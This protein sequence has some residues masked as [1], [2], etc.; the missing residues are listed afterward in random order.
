[1]SYS[2]DSNKL[3]FFMVALLTLFAVSACSSN[4]DLG[5][6]DGMT[7]SDP[8]YNGADVAATNDAGDGYGTASAV[9]GVD[10][11]AISGSANQAGLAANA[12]DIIYFDTDSS[13]VNADARY[14]LDAQARWLNNFPKT[15]ITVE[16]HAD[17]RGTREYN[18]AL[19]DRR[20]SAVK[21]YL[22]AIGIDP[23]R[24]N[25]ISYG[26]EQPVIVGTGSQSWAQNRRSQTRVR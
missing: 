6:S 21:N 19:G 1:M 5:D 10:S 24:I 8:N 25:T 22:I 17:E 2:M 20:A 9:G 4:K 7:I 15:S 16:G 3:T 23:R 14:I 18:L 12:G 11:M 13:N 26:K